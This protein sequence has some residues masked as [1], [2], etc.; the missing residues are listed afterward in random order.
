MKP[1]AAA[2][3]I[4]ADRQSADAA[5]SAGATAT[6]TATGGPTAGTTNGGTSGPQ[7]PVTET[8]KPRRFHG[9]VPID[10]LRV[11]RDASRIAEEVIQ[12]LTGMVGS[13]VEITLE[14]QA[15][16]ASDKL[17]R[18]VT[19]NCRTLTFTDYGFEED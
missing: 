18:D 8:P 10:P 15:D 9:S 11:G 14:I 4:D 2:A 17:V 12:H 19:E 3:Q 6:P 7:R 16:L 5:G 13:N 1:E